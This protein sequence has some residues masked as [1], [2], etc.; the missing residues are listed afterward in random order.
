MPDEDFFSILG[1]DNNNNIL[2]DKVVITSEFRDIPPNVR[3]N[4]RVLTNN[5]CL[6]MKVMMRTRVDIGYFIGKLTSLGITN[7]KL[8]CCS[9]TAF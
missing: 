6:S 2:C 4:G 5:E 7:V 8:R 1:E 9:I 3:T